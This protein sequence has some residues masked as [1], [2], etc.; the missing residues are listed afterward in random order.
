MR[1]ADLRIVLA[2][3]VAAL[4]CARRSRPASVSPVQ[5]E[6]IVAA[7]AER[8]SW[9]AVD[10]ERETECARVGGTWVTFGTTAGDTC[11][12]LLSG[13]EG[14]D[15]VVPSCDCGA[16]RCWLHHEGRATCVAHSD[17]GG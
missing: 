10:P 13:D 4:G 12:S 7:V 16:G 15:A 17:L 14:G 6:A 11:Y 5:A 9:Q 2:V 8:I 1:A 3:G